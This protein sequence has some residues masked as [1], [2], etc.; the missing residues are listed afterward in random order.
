VRRLYLQIYLAML[1]AL[2]VY[3]ALASLLWHAAPPSTRERQV[4]E[5][6]AAA[7]GE[8]LP[9]P[10][11][12][13]AELEAKLRYLDSRFGAALTVRAADGTHL[14]SSR[15]PL[16]PPT[17]AGGNRWW[18]GRH[19]L[20]LTLALPDGRFVLARHAHDIH[21]P[22]KGLVFAL[23]VLALVVA[24]AAY[25]VVR[26]LTGRLERLRQGVD[27][28]GRGAL[29][30]RVPVEGT[31]EVAALARSFNMSADRIESLVQSQRRVLA[32]ASHEL[33]SPL[34]RLQMAIELLEGREELKARMR[35]DVAELDE[36]IGELLVAS[37]LEGASRAE[38]S[39]EVD[40]LAL[41]A[42]EAA[43][44]GAA[45]SGQ[46]R[47]VRGDARLLRRLVRNLLENAR[48]HAG[49][50]Q[51]EVAVEPLGAGARVRVAD[52]GPGVAE[53]ER[54]RIFEPFYRPPGA[55]EADGGVGLG[56]ALVRQIARHHG[57]EARYVPRP[58]GGSTFEVDLPA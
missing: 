39:E 3:G 43:H 27:E 48:R 2:V 21:G 26:R 50:A 16:D 6:L 13:A 32:G 52:R 54:E 23:V 56:L 41:A 17:L 34:A 20:T 12:P 38:P 33:R 36:L 49:G 18:R 37:R 15:T 44:T 35:R 4:L 58:G 40:L 22:G 14:A 29:Q 46:S 53:G 31:D 11:R 57:G 10:G 8:L 7:V 30:A 24:A 19:G 51:V 25:P 9:P 42:E 55:S 5:G 28:L 45:V 1:A 47:T